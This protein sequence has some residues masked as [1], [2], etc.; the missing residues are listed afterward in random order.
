VGE[1]ELSRL[2]GPGSPLVVALIGE[3]DLSNVQPLKHCLASWVLE[4]TG[5]AIIDLTRAEFIDSTVIGTLVS[6][7]VAGLLLTVR[8]ASGVVRRVLD[9]AGVD[10]MLTIESAAASSP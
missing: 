3:F 7:H 4:G 5:A 10:E 8:G 9:T 1:V 6:A 2:D